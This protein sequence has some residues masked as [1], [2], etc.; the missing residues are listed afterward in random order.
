MAL[1][2]S[3]VTVSDVAG[4]FKGTLNVGSTPYSDQEVYVLPGTASNSVTLVMPSVA[5]SSKSNDLVLVDMG[6]NS[7]GTLT[8]G[9]AS[10]YVK[11]ISSSSVSASSMSFTLSLVTPALTT[12][13]T[14]SFSGSKVTNRNYAIT[15]GGFEGSWSNN[16][17]QGWHSFASA[18][19]TYASMAGGDDQFKQSNDIRPGST[20]SHSVVLASNLIAG[21]KA[22]GN[23]TNGRIN[24][25]STTADN[26][27]GNYNYSD[28]GSSGYNTAFVGNPDSLVFWAKYI[29][30]D[31]NPSNSVNKARAH[32]VVTTNA[33]YQ[34]PE[35]T[36]Y[37]DVKIAE[38][39]VNYSATSDMGW[40]RLSIPFVYSSV[41]PSKAAYVLVT[42]TTNQTPGGGSTYSTGSLFNQTYYY[43]HLYLDDAEMVYNHSLSSFKL[44]GSTISFSVD[45]LLQDYTFAATNNGK[46]AKTFV[47]FDAVNNRVQVYVVAQNYSQ[48]QAYSV[49]TLQMA[50]PVKDTEYAY[51]ASTCQNEPYSDNLFK[52]LTQAGEYKKTI[53]NTQGGD[54][55][56]TLTLTVLP[57]Y[58]IPA[59][60]SIR[61]DESY[62]WR[63]NTYENLV[64][65]VYQY[66]DELKTKAGCDS[67]Y[68]LKL[69][70]E[71]IPY[72]FSEEMTACQGEEATWHGKTLTTDQTGEFTVKDEYKSIYNT[73]SVYTLTL[74]VLPTYSIP[75]TA[76]ISLEESYT[77]R[78]NT[79]ENLAPGEYH[80]ADELKTKAGCDSVF[81]LTLTV[82]A[83]PYA[84]SEEMTACRNE[85]ATWH[86]KTLNTDQT[87]VFTVKDEYKSIYNTDSVYTLT[88]TVL[89]TYRFE[90]TK[91]VNEADFVWRG[92]TI[93]GLPQRSEPYL[94][95][96]SLL[97]TNDCDSI[98]VLVLHVS[99]I[100]I[101][102]G[103]YEAAMCD[104]DE[105]TFEG[106]KYREAF[107]GDVLVSSK[108][109]YGG[110]SIVHL[111][112]TILP[113]YEIE[114][115]MYITV[116]DDAEWEGWNLSTMP[117]GNMTLSAWYYSEDDCDSTM[118]LHLH[119]LP[120]TTGLNDTTPTKRVTRKVFY[121]GQLYIIREDETLYTILG[122]KIQ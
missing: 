15:N 102:Y 20:G 68:R 74:T 101:T 35:A 37:A 100:P 113:T 116:G 28:P 46:A 39:T 19:G 66:A 41:N 98:Y 79:Y 62:S 99:D 121:N 8:A 44:D 106:V 109:I 95:Y 45:L 72:A 104:G 89:P 119:V 122:N 49:Y 17:P 7:N 108:N 114:E 4:V 5:F 97:T 51:S 6:L 111:T 96:D 40:Q 2:A 47:G 73:D 91:Y 21:V 117:V 54:S 84:F 58:S 90:E 105:I 36:S 88:L 70:V 115:D 38:A 112:V 92:K 12:A 42:F 33:R 14:V 18:S 60:A 103:E 32:V 118:V 82:G 34:D 9:S 11:Q 50:E 56:I 30:A 93:Q 65:G 59:T 67:I 27:S 71:P 31:E 55:L 57:T 43:D 23:C 69:T 77:W 26:A 61:M 64:P 120:V 52:N 1:Q 25:G 80:Y 48:A 78:G 22:N 83:I 53:P 3:A 29:P 24:A 75:A 10:A 107:E 110:D 94:I 13:K 81:T 87:G 85:E 63:G 16:E 86:G 76:A